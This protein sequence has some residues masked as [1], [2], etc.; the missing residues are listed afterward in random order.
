[1]PSVDVSY[2]ILYHILQHNGEFD[3]H[4]MAMLEKLLG[5]RYFN[6]TISHLVC[7]QINL[8]V[9]LGGIGL[10]L[11]VELLALAFLGCWVLLIPALVIHFQQDDHLIVFDTVAHV[12]IGIFFPLLTL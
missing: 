4:T 5:T 10:P 12:E 2:Y 1:M 7:H 3:S 6:I 8:L 9:F 11:M